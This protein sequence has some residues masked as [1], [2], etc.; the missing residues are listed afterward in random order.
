LSV[1]GVAID[2][3]KV[4]DILDWKP[5]TTIHQVRSFLRMVGYYHHFISD[6]SKIAKPITELLKNQV[7]FR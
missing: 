4:K 2:P 1:E 7:K 6:F 3:G 5:P